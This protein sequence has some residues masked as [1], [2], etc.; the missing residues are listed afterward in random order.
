[1]SPTLIGLELRHYLENQ[2]NKHEPHNH[3]TLIQ[4]IIVRIIFIVQSYYHVRF[5]G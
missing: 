2:S 5:L 1:M 4:T 3:E